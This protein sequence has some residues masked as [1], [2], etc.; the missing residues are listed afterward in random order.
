MVFICVKPRYVLECF[1]KEN[2]VGVL[3]HKRDG[4]NLK[5][6]SEMRKPQELT[7]LCFPSPPA[8]SRR[9]PL[10]HAQCRWP[11][12]PGAARGTRGG[13]MQMRG[14]AAEGAAGKMKHS[15]AAEGEKRGADKWQNK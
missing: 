13:A 6:D 14:A 7:I 11:G 10:A 8:R 5:M 9:R 1:K 2:C 4:R 12:A 15:R 3:K